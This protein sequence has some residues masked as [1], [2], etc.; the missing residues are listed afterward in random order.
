MYSIL[1]E[2]SQPYLPEC[3]SYF[4]D[5]GIYFIVMKFYSGDLRGLLDRMR[6]GEDTFKESVAKNVVFQILNGILVD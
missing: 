1:K 5:Q 2:E 3:F 6:E 4:N